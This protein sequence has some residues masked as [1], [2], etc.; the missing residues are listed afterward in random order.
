MLI[1]S[2]NDETSAT[3]LNP[4]RAL[5]TTLYPRLFPREWKELS[6]PRLKTENARRPSSGA[7]KDAYGLVVC[8]LNARYMEISERTRA[9]HRFADKI[10]KATR[11]KVNKSVW[12]ENHNI[13]LLC[14]SLGAERTSNTAHCGQGVAIEIDGTI[15]DREFKMKKDERKGKTLAALGIML[16]SVLNNDFSYAPVRAI[17]DN[18]KTLPRLDSRAR[19]RVWTRIHLIT[20]ARHLTDAEFRRLFFETNESSD[21]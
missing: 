3:R 10:R 2:K 15:H 12:I 7:L 17:L 5:I 1:E 16:V 8:R 18:F 4:R 21:L 11:L 19:S 6:D 9:E 14:V 13:D 20:V